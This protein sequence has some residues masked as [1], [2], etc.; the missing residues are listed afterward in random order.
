MLFVVSEIQ[1]SFSSTG[2]AAP[3]LI[4]ARL[5]KP[6]GFKGS[7]L[8]ADDR[9]VNPETDRQCLI[10]P[11]INDSDGLAYTLKITDFSRCGVLKRNVNNN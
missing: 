8:F 1:C 3:D 4:T 9:S 10:R 6:A 7:P 5:K 2:S 11:E